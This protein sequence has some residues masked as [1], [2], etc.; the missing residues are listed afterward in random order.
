MIQI[1]EVA[2]CDNA[3]T[4]ETLLIVKNVLT[5]LRI[6]IPSILVIMCMV[7]VVQNVTSD[8]IDNGKMMKKISH[9]ILAAVC[10]FL[11]PS[12][13]NIAMHI[14]EGIELTNDNCWSM[15]TKDNVD[16][17]KQTELEISNEEKRQR[18]EKIKTQWEKDLKAAKKVKYSSGS[19]SGEMGDFNL[20]HQFDPRWGSTPLCNNYGAFSDSGCG[21]TSFA[22]IVNHFY[23]QSI[24]PPDVLPNICS[25]GEDGGA[26]ND[27]T[28]VNSSL[29]NKYNL[30]AN[31]IYGRNNIS[32]GDQEKQKEMVVEELDKGNSLIVLIPGHYVVFS[33]KQG[34]R[35][36]M[37]NPGMSGTSGQNGESGWYPNVDALYEA[38]YNYKGRC[39]GWQCGWIYI[40]SYN[41]KES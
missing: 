18:V 39:S 20:F 23:D 40:I 3:A 4:L 7:S 27:A 41:R 24:T 37:L 33:Q 36:Q 19:N 15:A 17:K 30:E 32:T 28:L 38:T 35:I 11:V 1:L 34:D 29:L 8:K 31:V 14:A 13:I 21:Y 6:V 22:M 12:I 9:K 2:T 25:T 5:I 16:M 10:I 26:I